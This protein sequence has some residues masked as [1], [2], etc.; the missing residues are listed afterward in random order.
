ML[1]IIIIIVCLA[2]LVISLLHSYDEL[3][4]LTSNGC[5]KLMFYHLPQ[6][7]DFHEMEGQVEAM[8]LEIWLLAQLFSGK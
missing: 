6:E 4:A 7:T 2:C 1:L 3:D 8:M 5:F